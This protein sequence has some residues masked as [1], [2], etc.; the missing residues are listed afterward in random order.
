MEKKS[1][2]A[3]LRE[4]NSLMDT[5]EIAELLQAR[6]ETVLRYVRAGKLPAPIKIGDLMRW[7]P[8]VIANALEADKVELAK[9][10]AAWLCARVSEGDEYV[11]PSLMKKVLVTLPGYEEELKAMHDSARPDKEEFLHYLRKRFR[12]KCEVLLSREELIALAAQL[13]QSGDDNGQ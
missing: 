10:V 3:I 1:I 12:Y 13:P 8:K 6:P 5:A 9:Q 11:T 2:A 7:D 4:R